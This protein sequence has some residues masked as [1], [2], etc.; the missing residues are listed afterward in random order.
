M[1][2]DFEIQRC[3]RRCAKTDKE[4]QPGESFYSVLVAEGK[5]V[6]RRDYSVAAWDGAPD[7]AIGFWK[8]RIP[9]PNSKKVNWAPN[10]VMLNYF[11]STENDPE[12]R[13]IR[14]VL[15]LLLLRRRIF[16]LEESEAETGSQEVMTLHCPRN[17][18][19]YRVD[20]I[21]PGSERAREIQN[22]VAQILFGGER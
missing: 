18:T 22:E 20:V 16:R 14:F 7:E 4:L 9:E 1:M 21:S 11:V 5:D 15:A 10:D 2:L 19:E 3:T 8:S 6:V 17:D 13:D 12:K